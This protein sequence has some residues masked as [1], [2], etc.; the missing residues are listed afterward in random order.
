[1]HALKERER[2]SGGTAS[3]AKLL[4]LTLIAALTMLPLLAASPRSVAAPEYRDNLDGTKS[5]I[6]NLDTAQNLTI[7]N[8]AIGDGVARLD[9]TSNSWVVTSYDDFAAGTGL[10]VTYFPEG[11]LS[12]GFDL[13]QERIVAARDTEN[14]YSYASDG[15]FQWTGLMPGKVAL[16]DA[17]D[18]DGDGYEDDVVAAANGSSN[19]VRV[20]DSQGGALWTNFQSMG[21]RG[22]QSLDLDRD[23][24][25]D[26][27]AV[28]GDE[29]VLSI[30]NETGATSWARMPGGIITSLTIA[31]LDANGFMDDIVV[32]TDSPAVVAFNRTGQQLW[33]YPAIGVVAK[34]ATVWDSSTACGS[35]IAVP[36]GLN[37][38]LLN[39]TG[40]MLWSNLLGTPGTAVAAADFDDDGIMDDVAV[41]FGG[42][43]GAIGNFDSYGNYLGGYTYVKPVGDLV[44]FDYNMMGGREAIYSGDVSGDITMLN[45]TGSVLRGWNPK[46]PVSS[47]TDARVDGDNFGDCVV[48]LSDGSIMAATGLGGTPWT[49]NIGGQ[50]NDLIRIRGGDYF[51]NVGTWDSGALGA[52][53]AVAWG[54][55]EWNASIPDGTNITFM[56][57]SGDNASPDP[58]WSNWSAPIW[59][60]GTAIAS[61]IAKHL[62]VRVDLVTTNVSV[63]PVLFDFTVG[64]GEYSPAGFLETED[65]MPPDL[66][67]WWT[68]DAAMVEPSSTSIAFWSSSDRGLSWLPLNPGD[69]LS[70]I[71]SPMLRFRANL[72]TSNT[73]V[74]PLLLELSIWYEYLG[75]LVDVVVS[76][77]TWTGRPGES[78]DF[79]ATG[80][81]CLGRPVTF[82]PKWETSDPLGVIDSDGLYTSGTI[83]IWRVYANETDGVVGYA[84][85]FVSTGTVS[86]I[87]IQPWNLGILIAGS[88][89]TLTA[90]GFDAIGIQIGPV[91][92]NW[93]VNG[94]V[95]QIS[96][97]GF[98]SSVTF[99]ATNVGMGSVT[100]NDGNSHANT[101]AQFRVVAGALSRIDV[102]PP[103]VNVPVDGIM[104]FAAA[105]FDAIGNPVA[106]EGSVWSTD[107][108]VLTWSNDS[109][110]ILQ[111]QGSPAAGGNVTIAVGTVQGRAIVNIISPDTVPSIAGTIPDQVK[112]EDYGTWSLD[113]LPMAM[114]PQDPPSSLRW[115]LIGRNAS[116]FSVTGLDIPGSHVLNFTTM[117]NA[118]GNNRVTLRLLDPSG[119][120][121]E[122]ALWINITP[123]NDRP[124]F[125]AIS[126]LV[127]H[128]DVPY[129]FYFYDYANDVETP[130]DRLILST[131]DSA[132]ITIDGLWATFTYPQSM[133]GTTVYPAFT[134]RDEGGATMTTVIAVYV[135]NDYVPTLLTSLPDVTL[136]EG[137]EL[138]DYFDLDDYIFDPDHDSLYYALGYSHVEIVIGSDHTVD[139]RSVGEWF[140]SESVRFVA[141]DPSGARVEDM[142]LVTVLPVNDP[143][144]ISGVPDLVVHPD[145]PMYPDYN[146]TFD[147]SPYIEDPDNPRDTLSVW[148][149]D[150]ANIAFYPPMNMLMSIHYPVSMSGMEVYVEIT[151][152]DGL[153][154]DTDSINIS[155]SQDWPPEIITDIP[156]QLFI[157]DTTLHN[158]FNISHYFTDMDGDNLYFSYGNKSTIVSIDPLT[159]EVDLSAKR[160][161]FGVERVTFRA[162]DPAGA[163]AECTISVTVIPV[164]DAPVI[165]PLPE[166]TA[167]AG[168]TVVINLRDYVSD[169]DNTF[170]EL[171][172][173]FTSYHPESVRIIEGYLLLNYSDSVSNDR[174]RLFVSDGDASVWRDIDVAVVRPQSGGF[175][176]LTWIFVVLSAVLLTVLA[177][178][179]ARK[180]LLKMVIEEALVIHSDGRLIAVESRP[181]RTR[182]GDDDI[183]SA[184]LTAI[185]S[186][187][188]DSFKEKEDAPLKR[189]EF[190]KEKILIERSDAFCLA[191][192]YSGSEKSSKIKAINDAMKKINAEYGEV[193]KDWGGLMDQVTGISTH[194]KALWR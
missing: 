170:E 5:A 72:A 40:R 83:G 3:K 30:L 174:L 59:I 79:N 102:M 194:L 130:K 86:R 43:A 147:L 31:D 87:E 117:P 179:V 134:V 183:F 17:Y 28:G 143:P 139:F 177:A 6:W 149:S 186:Y 112:P 131:T 191:I 10:N 70:V 155:I 148:T 56:T 107:V 52:A 8:V 35:R 162:S 42:N 20:F 58:G 103:N 71:L 2:G 88:T 13:G 137:Q 14:V 151:V 119:N 75:P 128:Y 46:V 73:S 61:P 144:I 78:H 120:S 60:S 135:T 190:G 184:M 189:V 132:H 80:Y 160:D 138:L 51:L 33:T 9:A 142:I 65:I 165:A 175:G 100:A 81:D 57:R 54:T 152:S 176:A 187:A 49:V 85:V 23:G 95:G 91:S 154:Q 164:N 140:G 150:P 50:V 166:I 47:V 115:R 66:V 185:Q 76:P 133:N 4:S 25:V 180:T 113:L 173:N 123:V 182:V 15:S 181:G 109:A 111:A 36:E 44:S 63:R 12:L 126:P 74:T 53:P 159:S 64:Y 106:L 156:D 89:V 188:Q 21:I 157:E 1:M 67:E 99:T 24:R 101:T 146:Y 93:L 153:E 97:P 192:V 172:F 104:S 136:F 145:D 193:L 114:D 178:F 129:N 32:A 22:L 84:D 7:N 124:T 96:P 163:M 171:Q 82:N 167:I 125:E 90:I 68:F 16:L 127:V 19:L 158:A 41:A 39:E 37:L 55:L 94:G 38:T 118:F 116:L 110:A 122:Q 92:S 121:D 26:E 27:V 141:L 11:S 29:G 98:V 108:G 168:E 48:G 45:E 62:Q 77:P 18:S 161:W 105:G 69:N 34:V 169:V